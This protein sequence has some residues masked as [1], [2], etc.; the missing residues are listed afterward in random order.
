ML[1]A[2]DLFKFTQ[3]MQPLEPLQNTKPSKKSFQTVSVDNVCPCFVTH[4]LQETAHFRVKPV[5]AEDNC[6]CVSGLYSKDRHNLFVFCSDF[7][8]LIEV[9]FYTE[10]SLDHLETF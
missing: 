3:C 7:H 5:E 2:C 1:L 6:S 4:N 8:Y 10:L 9:R